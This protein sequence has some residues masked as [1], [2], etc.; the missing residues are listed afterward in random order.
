MKRPEYHE[1]SERQIEAWRLSYA[2]YKR[3]A[4]KRVCIV[5]AIVIAFCFLMKQTLTLPWGFYPFLILLL[6]AGVLLNVVNFA[7]RGS[8]GYMAAPD[9]KDSFNLRDYFDWRSG[10]ASLQSGA[11]GFAGHKTTVIVSTIFV[12]VAVMT[13]GFLSGVLMFLVLSLYLTIIALWFVGL[14]HGWTLLGYYLWFEHREEALKKM[15]AP[16]APPN[17]RGA[18]VIEMPDAS[19]SSPSKE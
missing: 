13:F 15:L 10:W 7:F 17:V 9:G 12:V 16:R 6:L 1:M 3:S 5:G 4:A 2:D 19:S 8:D 14:T 18:Q 11:K